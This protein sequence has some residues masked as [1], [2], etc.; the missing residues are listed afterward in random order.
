MKD[1]IDRSFM[2][3][4]DPQ[5]LFKDYAKLGFAHPL[6]NNELFEEEKAE[7]RKLTDEVRKEVY[8]HMDATEAVS[9]LLAEQESDEFF[10]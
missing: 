1:Y 4:F 6:E 5:Y 10:E 3:L 7:E 9:Y 2:K 8:N